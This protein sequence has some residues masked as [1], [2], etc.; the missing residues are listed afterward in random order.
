LKRI[1]IPLPPIT[2]QH[3]IVR[4]VETLF[5]LADSIEKRVA[6]ASLDNEKLTPAV[7]GKAF[8]GEL[9]PTEAELARREGREFESGSE[10]LA[11]IR[12]ER[13]RHGK[14]EEVIRRISM[15]TKRRGEKDLG[16]PITRLSLL[17]VLE[18]SKKKLTPEE[19]FKEAGFNEDT[20][21]DFYEELR[22]GI[23]SRKIRELRPN[24]ADIYLEAIIP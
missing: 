5:N 7:L 21:E 20:I 17:K 13:E 16:Q 24:D 23:N 15:A 3:E 14:E 6:A 8:R 18:D 19:L 1:N 4:R 22:I 12:S 2:E 11:R 9:V 10:L